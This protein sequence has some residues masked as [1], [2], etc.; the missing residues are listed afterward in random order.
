MSA[1]RRRGALQG[2][3][4]EHLTAARAWLNR[5]LCLALHHRSTSEVQFSPVE[6]YCLKRLARGLSSGRKVGPL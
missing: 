3:V 6:T 5:M 2:A 1:Q 4:Q